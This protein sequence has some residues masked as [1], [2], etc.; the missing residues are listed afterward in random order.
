M[1]NVHATFTMGLAR[2]K[3]LQVFVLLQLAAAVHASVH[4]AATASLRSSRVD[5]MDCYDMVE[6]QGQVI[7]I[8]AYGY[9]WSL[10]H[11]SRVSVPP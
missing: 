6:L 11:T 4:V 1:V 2:G 5:L 10:H 7:L 3:Q 8:H 9:G